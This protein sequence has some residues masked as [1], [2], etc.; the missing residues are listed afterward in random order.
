[1]EANGN[2][3]PS[4]QCLLR[5]NKLLIINYHKV[6]LKFILRSNV[7]VR[8]RVCDR[9]SVCVRGCDRE[10]VCVHGCVCG[11]VRVRAGKL[12]MG[13]VICGLNCSKDFYY[14]IFSLKTKSQY[15][16]N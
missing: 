16:N 5:I 12:G 6:K 10:S 9:E 2:Q 13:L 11:G 14:S 7:C 3:C 15:Q 8:A 1:M 4:C